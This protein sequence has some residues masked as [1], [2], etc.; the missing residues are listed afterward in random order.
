MTGIEK[1]RNYLPEELLALDKA[2]LNAD[3]PMSY[4]GAAR[5]A[6]SPY[7]EIV[8]RIGLNTLLY[9]GMGDL[10][11]AIK[12]LQKD[13][14]EQ[15]TGK[16]TVWQIDRLNYMSSRQN[17]TRVDFFTFAFGGHLVGD[18]ARVEGTLE[19]LGEK[20]AYPINNVRI[21]CT[22]ALGTCSY[23]QIALMLPDQN[24]WAQSYSVLEV[25][26][27]T[28]VVTRWQD[29][30][31]D[32]V[33]LTTA[34]C[35]TNTLSLNFA[36]NEFYEISKNLSGEDC[37]SSLG[38]TLPKLEAPRISRIVDGQEIL[39]TEFRRIQ[40]ESYGFLS[41]DFRLKIEDIKAKA[42]QIEVPKAN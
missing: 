24:S 27:E 7:G 25:A 13:L 23:R 26:N 2:V 18:F 32:A 38:V 39:N 37:T 20:I 41:S 9:D 36:A 17:M 30:Q 15:Q 14:G 31:I 19:I 12:A 8:T 3:V 1:Y 6:V 21:E 4:A 10:T 28:Y 33:P 11:A 22:Q 35:R 5:T 29:N 40:D 16:L 34:G 42:Q